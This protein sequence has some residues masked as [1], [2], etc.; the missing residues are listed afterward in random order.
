MNGIPLGGCPVM[1][2]FNYEAS[3]MSA[4]LYYIIV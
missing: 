4:R 1:L 3:I 2:P